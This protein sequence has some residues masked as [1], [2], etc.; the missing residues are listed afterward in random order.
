MPAIALTGFY[1]F[2]M[3]TS[4]FTAFLCKP[5]DLDRICKALADAIEKGTVE[6]RRPRSNI[7]VTTMKKRRRRGWS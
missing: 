3:D 6:R 2:Y 4:G 5:V 1:E 7:P